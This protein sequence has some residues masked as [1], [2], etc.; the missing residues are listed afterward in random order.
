MSSS[1]IADQLDNHVLVER[2]PIVGRQL[3]DENHSL[4]IVS[5]D[6]KN[7]R[8]NHF[9]NLSAVFSRPSILLSIRGETN[10]VVYNNV[11]S[12]TCF[13]SDRLGHLKC[14]HNHALARK[15][16]IPMNHNWTNQVPFFISTPI[17]ARSDRALN[18]RSDN[19]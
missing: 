12:T 2:H 11:N 10:L 19:L 14:L 15:C 8:L 7:W 6:V 1:A 4:R 17:L 9:R 5:V 18:N 13:E 3:S 16:S